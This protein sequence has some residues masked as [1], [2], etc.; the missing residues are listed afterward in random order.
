MTRKLIQYISKYITT[1]FESQG[2]TQKKVLALMF[3][4]YFPFLELKDTPSWER[5]R[6]YGYKVMAD[7]PF[8]GCELLSYVSINL[9][10]ERFTEWLKKSNSR[11][12]EKPI[13]LI[14]DFTK[15]GNKYG[16]RI[17]LLYNLYDYV[18]QCYINTHQICPLVI[19][20]GEEEFVIDYEL[21]DPT[22]RKGNN[23]IV[24]EMIERLLEYLGSYQDGSLCLSFLHW[25]RLTLDGGWGN[26]NMLNWAFKK[27]FN[28]IVFKSGGKDVV[29]FY[30]RG[31]RY[32]RTL[33]ELESF[34]ANSKFTT[35]RPF[36]KTHNLPG[37][38]T[39]L[40]VRLIKQNIW[41][42]LLL[43]C[44]AHG[45]LMLLTPN[46]NLQANRILKTYKR[47]WPIE[48]LI[49]T[50]KQECG[51]ERY[52]FHSPDTNNIELFIGMRLLLENMIHNY[53]IKYTKRS[54][55]TLKDVIIGLN[56]EFSKMRPNT[57]QK[58]F[59]A[60][61]PVDNEPTEFVKFHFRI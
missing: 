38:Y 57:F 41:I 55:T 31:K 11:K 35:W 48:V 39:Y 28:F 52:S 59:P 6:N 24:Q 42:K 30:W 53:R 51:L 12:S 61:S 7:P 36:N 2:L 29:E 23:Q 26:G 47:R 45:Y 54:K 60:I 21:W 37:V 13:E 3:W 49:R 1:L 22:N 32:T 33:K 46:L 34:L 17:P 27:G 18:H 16:H 25:A 19:C 58:L 14:A 50:A 10:I 9:F 44:F 20:L 43:I 8:K 56:K 15:T 40:N 4:M 5:H